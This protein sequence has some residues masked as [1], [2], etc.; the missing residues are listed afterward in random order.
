MKKLDFFKYAVL[1]GIVLLLAAGCGDKDDG[2]G[3]AGEIKIPDNPPTALGGGLEKTGGIAVT[4]ANRDDF[5][6]VFLKAMDE[7]NNYNYGPGVRAS[8]PEEYEKETESGKESYIKYGKSGRVEITQEWEYYEKWTKTGETETG[9]ESAAYKFFDFSNY[10]SLFLGGAL[11]VLWTSDSKELNV[12]NYTM[13]YNGEI[14]F[15]GKYQGKVVFDNVT[16]V[17]KHKHYYYDSTYNEQYDYW[18]YRE[19]TDTITYKITG[20]SF[21][22]QSVGGDSISLPARLLDDIY[23]SSDSIVYPEGE[24]TI[25]M[26]DVPSAPSG[27]L[28]NHAGKNTA[29]TA[30]NVKDFFMAYILEFDRYDY[31]PR[32]VNE[33]KETW[34]WLQH[35]IA[36]GYV[37]YKGEDTYQRNNSGGYSS[38]TS[39]AEYHNYSNTGSLYI[40]GGL[41]SALFRHDKDDSSGWSETYETIT[42]GKMKF[43]GEFK[44]ELVFDKFMCK[45]EYGSGSNYES[46][47]TYLSG[48]VKIG[49]IDVTQQYMEYVEQVGL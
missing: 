49:T 17:D 38:Q 2:S 5:I 7:W 39:I 42:N 8:L 10:D 14:D 33:E 29:V 37:K 25:K 47:Y 43:N 21:Y 1:T 32:A 13:K 9:Y 15:A 27:A 28:S 41:G 20:G 40:G 26:P 23:P 3:G 24:I 6:T 4:K 34:E 16:F 35:G 18:D 45:Y 44:C 31:A 48:S 11:G 12:C 30:D 46:R 36:S 19:S 22:V